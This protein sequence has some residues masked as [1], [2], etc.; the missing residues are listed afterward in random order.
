MNS[1]AYV[2]SLDPKDGQQSV[3]M[4]GVILYHIAYDR[5]GKGTW[6]E[7]IR[8]KGTLASGQTVRVHSGSGPEIVLLPE[9]RQGATHHLFTGRDQYVWNNDYG[10]CSA[11]WQDGQANP[12]DNACYDANPPEGVIL[13]RVGDRLVAP[14]TTKAA[15]GRRW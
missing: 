1:L 8:F 5:N 9:D 7:V 14:A 3:D 15:A 11:L 10:D 13:V 6:E 4:T 12:F 2:F